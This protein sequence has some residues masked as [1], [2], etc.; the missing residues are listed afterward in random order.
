MRAS[1]H[2]VDKALSELERKESVT[3]WHGC[4][5]P[6]GCGTDRLNESHSRRTIQPR[7]KRQRRLQTN[8]YGI[9]A[10][11]RQCI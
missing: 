1:Y 6:D 9:V 11:L 8:I 5:L 2:R 10:G 7:Y 4:S 3:M